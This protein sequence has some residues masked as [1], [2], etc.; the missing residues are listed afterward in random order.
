MDHIDPTPVTAAA[1]PSLPP[2]AVF[3][4]T[5][6]I[7]IGATPIG[8]TIGATSPAG[9]TLPETLGFDAWWEI[10][11]RLCALDRS[12]GFW[13][14]DWWAYGEHR[15]GRRSE[16]VAAGLF[17][18]AAKS[19]KNA[20]S[21]ARAITRSRR[22]DL[23]SFT[24]HAA[25]AALPPHQGDAL[26][27]R[28][29]RE[30]LS[31]RALRRLARAAQSGGNAPPS[32]GLLAPPQD[33]PGDPRE[34]VRASLRALLRRHIADHGRRVVIEALDRLRR[35]VENDRIPPQA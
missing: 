32:P 22:R 13:I 1:L 4:L 31:V 27:D 33:P 11:A 16:L 28:A 5:G 23:L 30:R 2:T 25:V 17:G 19:L 8:T 34:A 7:P 3:A 18:R 24:H 29:E 10:G 15:Y 14:G 9:L 35:E 6:Q 20:G 12:V 26:L 21:V